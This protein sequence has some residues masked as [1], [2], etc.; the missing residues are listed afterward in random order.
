MSLSRS[1]PFTLLALLG[2][3]W[4][5]VRTLIPAFAPVPA[6]GAPRLPASE[7]RG[8]V[9]SVGSETAIAPVQGIATRASPARWPAEPRSVIW[10]PL[11]ELQEAPPADILA[12]SPMAD[13]TRAGQ[14]LPAG[15]LG[16]V[17]APAPPR[18]SLLS[19]S[20]QALQRDRFTL[21]A[22]L[23][24]RNGNGAPALSGQAALG[25]SQAGVRA[26]WRLDRV[27]RVE[28]FTRLSSAGRP[29]D[30]AEGALGIAFRPN[31][32]LPVQFVAERRQALAGDD[33][34]SAFA[35]YA[36]GGVDSL[37]G[38]PVLVDAYAAAGVVGFRS[39]ELFAE[40]S[41]VARIPV[42]RLGPVDLSAGGGA[43]AAAQPGASRVDV[44]PRAQLRWHQGPVRPVV[45]LD[46]RQRV[47]GDAR[48]QSGP[49]LTV[50][51]DF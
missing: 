9:P 41:A 6:D 25:G 42:A 32:R 49:A 7:P 19:V 15:D 23:F 26:G 37:P 44:G 12:G 31:H 17:S 47:A 30:G 51:V 35:A 29:G 3:G 34:R 21:S 43:W 38:G 14:S 16:G 18:G 2:V 45:S 10:P 46:W 48:P 27:G 28:A 5:G 22:W 20:G 13:E 33:G 36:V 50:G 40:G 1:R 39:R 24:A 11:L 8:P 4:I